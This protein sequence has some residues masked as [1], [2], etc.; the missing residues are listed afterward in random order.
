METESLEC[1]VFRKEYKSLHTGIRQTVDTV[2]QTAF[3]N[4]LIPEDIHN[5][6][7][8]PAGGLTRE[9]RTTTFLNAV[10]DR[11]KLKPIALR[12]FIEILEY[13]KY[14]E[15]LAERLNEALKSESEAM[16]EEREKRAQQQQHVVSASAR[17]TQNISMTG[18][19]N[20]S[21]FVS[22]SQQFPTSSNMPGDDLIFSSNFQASSQL[23]PSSTVGSK[24]QPPKSLRFTQT[25]AESRKSSLVA[26]SP[27]LIWSRNHTGNYTSMYRGGS[28]SGPAAAH[29][30]SSPHALFEEANSITKRAMSPLVFAGTVTSRNHSLQTTPLQTR[31]FTYV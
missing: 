19:Y 4:L 1:R 17:A 25:T 21:A 31:Q 22:Q 29:V 16:T 28:F 10:Q 20:S 13:E 12:S 24:A 18:S 26:G 3:S 14:T 30:N 7:S 27:I 9:A 11:I 8:N 5:I 23:L 2:V 15:I 6:A